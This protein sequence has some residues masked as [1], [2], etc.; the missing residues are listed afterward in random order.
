[1]DKKSLKSIASG[2]SSST[3]TKPNK[4][5]SAAAEPTTVVSRSGTIPRPVHRVIENFLFVWLD[6]NINETKEDFKNSLKQLRHLG[7]SITTFTDAEECFKFLS[8]IKKEKIF[9]IVSGALGRQVA[10]EMQAMPQLESIY[11]F[12]GNKSYHEEWAK[13]I[14]KVKG[15]YTDIKPIC[16]ALEIDRAMISISFNGL[17]PL[18]MYT[19]LLKEA[20]F[21]IEDDD[22][23][24][25]KAFVDY[26]REQNDIP[27][28]QLKQ[29]ER[30]YRNH[31]AIWW[32]TVETFIYSMINRGL[33]QM[34]VNIIFNMGFFVCHLHNHIAKL[35][36]EQKGHN[37]PTKFQIFR[38][39][40]LSM[41]DFEKMKTTKGGLRSFN[42][43]LSTS[44]DRKISPE[45]FARPA[46]QNLTLVSI[47]FVMANDTAICSNS[48]TPFAEVSKVGYYKDQEEEILFT[49]R[50]IFR[51]DRTERV[52]DKHTDRLWQ[53][54][55]N[56]IG[57]LENVKP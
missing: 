46:T 3:T 50:K 49:T 4:S 34:D 14:P 28:G 33:R 51:I 16:Q 48:S 31:A 18:F 52:E 27:K 24:S 20:L 35:H 11:V 19:Q 42:N 5:S 15:V 6:A 13:T 25:I 2:S 22:K 57:N 55:L 36:R 32:Y 23:K 8:E 43:F 26:Y 21:E 38:G 37:M 29:V 40:G 45:N 53:V 41:E 44:R 12:C 17:N 1:M 10:P 9:I 54:N 47:L 39:Q 56:M 7:A 30:E